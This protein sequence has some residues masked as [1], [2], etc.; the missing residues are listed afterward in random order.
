MIDNLDVAVI[1]WNIQGKVVSN[2]MGFPQLI[3]KFITDNSGSKFDVIVL[4]F[5][6]AGT[7][8]RLLKPASCANM[9]TYIRETALGIYDIGSVIKGEGDV[10]IHC[11]T[12]LGI[13]AEGTLFMRGLVL[14]ILYRSD[15]DI[16]FGDTKRVGCKFQP[17]GKGAIGIPAKI[18]NQDWMF[19]TAHLP[20]NEK[21]GLSQAN[22]ERMNCFT[23][24]VNEMDTNEYDYSVLGG[25]LN[26]RLSR[27]YHRDTAV[28]KK[29]IES[30]NY[31]EL[32]KTDQLTAFLNDRDNGLES[33]W[34]EGHIG[35]APTC[36]MAKNRSVDCINNPEANPGECYEMIKIKSGQTAESAPASAQRIPSWCDRILVSMSDI[37]QNLSI[38]VNKYDR[39]A[40]GGPTTS[41]HDPVYATMS[42]PY[43]KGRR[44]VQE[45]YGD[46]SVEARTALLFPYP[47]S[48]EPSF[49]HPPGGF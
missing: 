8:L 14:A 33:T 45:A 13:G 46:K 1:S 20:F 34:T 40:V 31:K 16:S 5:Q 3:S 23:D 47:K 41:D 17:A 38:N 39:I 37:D 11:K 49:Y 42:T 4:E 25:D 6:E 24:V 43:K 10:K 2:D 21:Q 19:M 36:K 22:E 32:L 15:T 9:E 35:F 18:N 7:G 48:Y 29:A 44:T 12:T 26:F 27:E 28:L 30:G